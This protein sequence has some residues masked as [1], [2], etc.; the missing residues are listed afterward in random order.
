DIPVVDCDGMGRAFPELQMFTPTIY[1]MPCYPATLADDKGQRAV[2]IEA[3]SPKLVE[4][5]FRG[6]CVAMGCS[7]GFV[8][9]PLKKEDI[10]HKTVQNSTSRAW[11]LGHAVLKARAQKKDPF[12]A[13]LDFENGKSLCKGK[14]IDV[15]RRNEGGFTRGVL[16][17]LGLAEF[18]DEV[19][20]I[21]FQNENLV[22]TMH[23]P[24]GQ[25]EVLVCTPDLICIVDTETGEPIMTEEVR[26]GLRVS[27][28]GI[29]AHPLLLTEQ[30]LKYM[31]PQ[32]FGYSKE[33]VEFK[34]IG[35]YKDHG[36]VAPV[37]VDSCTS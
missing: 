29:P 16:K 31:G 37:S 18:Q 21:K 6:V 27:V 10:L 35:D 22:A 34:P 11:G 1:G 12:Q 9:T 14:I 28:L 33:E 17:I 20:I 24:N 2:I 32:A 15:E 23:H 36:P 25:K 4:D 30:A 7:A 5:H 13:I 26:Y 3:P 19:L 8:F